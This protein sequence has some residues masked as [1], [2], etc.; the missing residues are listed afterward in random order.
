[1]HAHEKTVFRIHT[2]QGQKGE[3]LIECGNGNAVK[4]A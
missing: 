3:L 4:Y 1:M 2:K